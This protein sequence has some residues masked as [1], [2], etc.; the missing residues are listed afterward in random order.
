MRIRIWLLL[1]LPFIGLLTFILFFVPVSILA[2]F[3]HSG[4]LDDQEFELRSPD[5]K[6]V[7]RRVRRNCGAMS[8][9][10]THVLLRHPMEHKAQEV[11]AHAGNPEGV[12]M[13]WQDGSRTLVIEH[14]CYGTGKLL[15]QD[16]LILAR[17]VSR[18]EGYPPAVVHLPSPVQD[19]DPEVRRIAQ[20]YCNRH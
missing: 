18:V 6:Y 5:R 1:L 12:R 10:T 11:F 19:Q 17:K 7:A 9:Y 14:L 8:S 16:V 13:Y 3:L 15:W 20:V 4:C 2:L